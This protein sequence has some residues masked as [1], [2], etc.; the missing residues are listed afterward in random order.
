MRKASQFCD[1][2]RGLTMR[3]LKYFSRFFCFI[4]FFV[5]F[6]VELQPTLTAEPSDPFTVLEGD[7]ITLEWSYDLRGDS[8]RRI[9]FSE[10]T[11]SPRILILEMDKVGQTP[12]W[13]E[14]DY[15]GR[16]QVNVTTTQTSITIL[17]ANRT[18]DSKDYQF[19]IVQL[20]MVTSR[21]RISVQCKYNHAQFS[22]YKL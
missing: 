21:V 7:N 18:V 9:E 4:L 1:E 19:A 5:F 15:N 6:F 2:S 22:F 16:L 20:N 3:H 14:D 12:A 13:L 11:S 10:I 17:G 8:F